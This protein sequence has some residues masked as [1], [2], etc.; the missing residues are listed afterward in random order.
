MAF[1]ARFMLMSGITLALIAIFAIAAVV[2]AVIIALAF[3]GKGHSVSSGRGV[4]TR[5]FES[6]EKRA[7][8]LGEKRAAELIRQVMREE[9]WLFTNVCIELDG[10]MTELDSVIVNKYGVFIIEVK[11]Y[12]G[13][14]AGAENDHE[15]QK[16]KT[17]AA[18]NTY[19]KTVRNPIPQV[20]RQVY[21]LAHFLEKNGAK[22]WVRGYALLLQGNAPIES[23]YLL[24]SPEQIERAIHARDRRL[25]APREIE[26]IAKLLELLS[27]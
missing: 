14:L 18:G 16:Y 20:K 7:G 15:W 6:G 21:L 8:R 13:L 2:A 27:E 3:P 24:N 25:L 12:N 1:A 23:E 17:T 9:D 19:D 4:W 11:N 10:R 5:N 22:V 26:T